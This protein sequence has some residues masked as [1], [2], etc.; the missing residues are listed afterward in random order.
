MKL[1]L[2]SLLLVSLAGNLVL[3]MVIVTTNKHHEHEDVIA[4]Q[5]KS[6]VDPLASHNPMQAALQTDDLHAMTTQLNAS[7]LPPWAVR[8]L[9]TARINAQF[10]ARRSAI[11][12]KQESLPYWKAPH[13]S[14]FDPKTMQA[15]RDLAH[16]Q[17]HMVKDLLGTDESENNETAVAMRKMQY[18]NL[19]PAKV[20]QLQNIKSDYEDMRSEIYAG[21]NG[22]MLP[23]DMAKL[24]ML[25]KEEQDDVTKL[26]SP[27][28]LEE[29][30]LHSSSTANQL[31]GQ[32]AGFDPTEDEFKSLFQVQRDFDAKYGSPDTPLSPEQARQ[33]MEAQSKLVDQMRA[34]LSP[35]RAAQFTAAMDPETQ[36]VSRLVDRLNLPN[37]ATAEVLSVQKDISQRANQINADPSL[38]PDQRNKSLAALNQ[39][40]V[41]KLT[42]VLGGSSG[43]DAYKQYGGQWLRTIAPQPPQVTGTN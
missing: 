20:E 42:S 21:S 24:A 6:Q 22:L 32:L 2:A 36:T 13:R 35:D 18:G 11:L 17:N 37:T 43:L 26:L 1:P 9:I 25:K 3:G 4:L 19:P 34:V 23:D 40:A 10:D 33:R 29:Y 31:R 28:E 14:M 27:Q 38:T 41:T 16:E 7:G 5:S 8:A 15:L 39:E 12:G 30:E